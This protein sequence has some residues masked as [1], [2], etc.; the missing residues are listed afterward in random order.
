MNTHSADTELILGIG[1]PFGDDQAGWVVIEALQALSLPDHIRL[2][3]LD[4]PGSRLIEYLGQY[5]RITLI[6]AVVTE[7]QPVGT[8]LPLS[9]DQLE[10]SQPASSHGLGL[11]QALAL[12]QALGEWPPSLRIFGICIDP[13]GLEESLSP[14]VI[15]GARQLAETLFSEM[16]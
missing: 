9:L 4:R 1:S 8:W 16:D 2:A 12:I 15:K 6:D 5:D 13:P 3:R 10:Q 11:A 7:D 14:A